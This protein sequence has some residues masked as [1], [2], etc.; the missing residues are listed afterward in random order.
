[1]SPSAVPGR[2][3]MAVESH[4]RWDKEE[5]RRGCERR[6]RGFSELFRWGKRGNSF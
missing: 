4:R 3:E 1:M 5:E 6:A 2:V